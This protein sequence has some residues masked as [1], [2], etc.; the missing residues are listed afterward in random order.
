MRYLVTGGAGFIGSNIV[1]SLLTQGATVRV[2]DNFATGKRENL[3]D[4]TSSAD[5]E[6]LVGDLRDFDVVQK[7]VEGVDY[8]LHQGALPSVPR[9]LSDPQ[10][11]NEVNV[12]GTMNVLL[13]A[14]DAGVKRVVFASSSSVYGETPTLPKHEA[15]PPDPLSPYAVSKLAGEYYCK[16]FGRNFGLP[17]V[18]LRY[19]NVFGPRQDPTSQYAAVIP[20]F[21]TA[22]LEDRPLTVYGDGEQSR[23][24]TYIQNVVR[25]NLLACTAPIDG[26]AVV[27]IACQQRKSLNEMIRILEGIVGRKAQV[28]YDP[29]R[30]GDIKHSLADISRAREV[31]GYEPEVDFETGLRETV[32][33]FQ[34]H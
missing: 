5:F 21:I 17:V 32:A 25:A 7:A 9:S 16:V 29:P 2:L 14:R 27:N 18:C 28:Q 10:A 6:L 34:N 13:A 30:P 4:Y 8:V 19:F 1:E 11:S 23:D 15:L 26:P 22:L 12:N 31:L 33:W 3:A 24:F 20:K